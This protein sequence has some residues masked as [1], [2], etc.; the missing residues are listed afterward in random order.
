MKM[1]KKKKINS[2]KQTRKLVQPNVI[3]QK[4]EDNKDG[5]VLQERMQLLACVHSGSFELSKIL[6][7][8]VKSSKS[9]KKQI[10]RTYFPLIYLGYRTG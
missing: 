9:G 1:H 3:L 5:E 10:R 2:S 6:R 7:I 4:V 8:F